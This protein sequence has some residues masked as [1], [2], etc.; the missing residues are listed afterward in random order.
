MIFNIKFIEKSMTLGSVIGF[1]F[2]GLIVGLL[3]DSVKL[4]QLTPK[5]RSIKKDFYIQLSEIIIYDKKGSIENGKEVFRIAKV[6]LSNE[7]KEFPLW[8][9][10]RWVMM[11]HTSKAF[12]VSSIVWSFLLY[13]FWNSQ[14]KAGIYILSTNE[15]RVL[16]FSI[17]IL[18]LLIGYKLHKESFKILQEANDTYKT[19]VKI[20]K[21]KIYQ[22]IL[23]DDLDNESN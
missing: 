22:F 16:I 9:H 2:I 23:E 6:I 21:K 1:L 8:E 3:M 15:S 12:F 19:Y 10:S 14:L 5:Y 4:Y 13:K 18:I 17:I 20:N 7:G 11:N